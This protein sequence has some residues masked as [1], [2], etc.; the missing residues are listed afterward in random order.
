VKIH[1]S[2][3]RCGSFGRATLSLCTLALGATAMAQQPAAPARSEI[4]TQ[5][6]AALAGALRTPEERARD[7]VERKP[8]QT[9]EFFGLRADMT[10]VELFPGAGWYTKILAPVLADKGRLYVAPGSARLAQQLKD[11]KLDRVVSVDSQA[12]FKPTSQ[13]GVFEADVVTIP[14]ENV[15]LVVTFRNLHNFTPETRARLH[16]EVLRMLKP[17]GIY[18]VKDH[19]RRHMEPASEENWRRLDPVVAIREITAAGFEF[20]DFS[21]LH[22]RPD[23]ALQFDTQRESIKG[24]SDRFTLKFRK[25]LK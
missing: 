17:G 10:V 25:P 16:A 6:E 15:D 7:A 8:V 2:P 22:H 3:T 23:D 9:L 1:R 12:A 4:A 14:V 13:R 11:W 24:Y 21:T 18:G 20:V 19:T 5:I